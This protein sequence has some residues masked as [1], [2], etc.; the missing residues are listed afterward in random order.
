[1]HPVH[2]EAPTMFVASFVLV[3]GLFES[4]ALCISLSF[5]AFHELKD[6]M[7]PFWINVKEAIRSVY[8]LIGLYE[9][10]GLFLR[11]LA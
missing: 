8:V 9:C 11:S 4:F 7:P 1:M 6:W 10:G 3:D 2:V 5:G